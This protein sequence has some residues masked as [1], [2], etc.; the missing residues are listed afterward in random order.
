MDYRTICQLFL[1]MNSNGGLMKMIESSVVALC[2]FCNCSKAQMEEAWT[3]DQSHFEPG[4]NVDSRQYA[5]HCGRM[6]STFTAHPIDI[7]DTQSCRLR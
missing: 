3:M 6:V 4:S 7:N 5:G 1:N 2:C